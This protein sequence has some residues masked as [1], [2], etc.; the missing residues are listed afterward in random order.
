[1]T[2]IFQEGL[3]IPVVRLFR[4]GELQQDILDLLLLNVRVAEERR[5][6]YNAQ[7]AACRLGLRRV[8]EI[9]AVHGLSRIH[10]AFQ[11]IIKRT[12]DRMRLAIS[13]IA[14]GTYRFSD[15]MDDDG[16]STVDIPIEV[17]ITVAADRIF[18]DFT[19]TSGQVDG[20]INVTLN[21]TRASVCYALK[22]LFDPAAPNNEGVLAVAEINAEPGSLLN[23]SF[24]AAVA[25]R[26]QTCQRIVDV[27]IGA[28]APAL[29]DRAVAASNGANT[30]AVFSGTDPRTGRAY[31]YL[32]TLGGGSGG[33]ASKDGK[34]G[35]QVNVTN[36]S[37]L[38]IEAIERE[39]PLLVTEYAFV[40][41]SGG[42]GQFRGGLGLRRS[43]KPVD[44]TC[45]FS[46]AGERF[47]HRPWGLFGGQSGG[48][49]R[50]QIRDA[51]GSTRA[52][53]T[54]PANE[55]VTPDQEVIVETPGAGGY[56]EPK[57]RAAK[58]ITDDRISGKS[59]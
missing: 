51:G 10:L 40:E 33:R 56:G 15:V 24:P 38:P 50:F 1:M 52:L 20:N 13:D 11:Q 25:S 4:E 34:D 53:T 12:E 48:T 19:G 49:G 6:D 37:N 57:E 55:I 44:H 35:V 29:P 30:T 47:T 45:L 46:G 28:L 17:E 16:L 36:T 14:D 9:A 27:I 3:R 2:E 39:Y 58:A 8:E 22:A 41:G 59:L 42:P 26:G 23:A 18:F 54:K 7:I 32:E 21:A 31:V 43:I 5:G